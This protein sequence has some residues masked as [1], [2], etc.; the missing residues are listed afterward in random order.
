MFWR[1]A[2]AFGFAPPSSSA[3]VERLFEKHKIAYAADDSDAGDSEGRKLALLD[4]LLDS[5]AADVL[6]ECKVGD[7]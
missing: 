1:T 3:A 2:P 7:S 5:E 4:A 6:N